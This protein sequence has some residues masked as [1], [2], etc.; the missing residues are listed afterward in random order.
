[1]YS[2]YHGNKVHQR[3]DYIQCKETCIICNILNR[4]GSKIFKSNYGLKYHLTTEH[5]V[6]D[7]I[8][9]GIT[10]SEVLTIVRAVAVALDWNMLIELPKRSEN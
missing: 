3:E 6:E 9:S 5:N 10:R 4:N 2:K 8:Q 1:M 7:E